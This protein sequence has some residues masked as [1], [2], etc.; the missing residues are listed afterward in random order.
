M[1]P[2]VFLC[3]VTLLVM[4]AVVTTL[5]PQH[6]GTVYR[7]FRFAEFVAVLWLLTPWWGRR[8]LLLVRAT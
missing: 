5:Q 1:R 8:D 4:E 2:N 7:I 3:L 6:V